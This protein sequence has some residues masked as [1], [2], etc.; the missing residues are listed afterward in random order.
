MQVK[1]EIVTTDKQFHKSVGLQV[2]LSQ[3]GK[4]LDYVLKEGTIVLNGFSEQRSISNVIG[5]SAETSPA[6]L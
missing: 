3:L 2:T 1:Y 5:V 6:G 4:T